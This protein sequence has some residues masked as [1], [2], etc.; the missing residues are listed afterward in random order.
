MIDDDERGL[1]GR[2]REPMVHVVIVVN[3]V[4]VR[5]RRG[6][7][8]RGV[9]GLPALADLALTL[10]RAGRHDALAARYRRELLQLAFAE[11]SRG[12]ER[13]APLAHGGDD[14]VAERM[15]EAAELG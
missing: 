13:G 15:H 4:V 6:A 1:L 12:R 11:H 8:G 10:G 3:V 14:V 9:L 7:F 2:R 5:V